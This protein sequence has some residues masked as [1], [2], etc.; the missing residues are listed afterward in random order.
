MLNKK[1]TP[2]GLPRGASSRAERPGVS[3][4]KKVGEGRDRTD[5]TLARCVNGFYTVHLPTEGPP[6]IEN[7]VGGPES[8]RLELIRR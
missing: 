1:K 8:N 5:K 3:S 6:R 2:R 7:S 4:K